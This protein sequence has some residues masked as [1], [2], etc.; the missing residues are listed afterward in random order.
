L[1]N[2]KSAEKRARVSERRRLINSKTLS[3]VRSAEKKVR[4]AIGAK[5]KDE[6]A[7][8][9]VVFKS[10]ITRAAQKGRMPVRTASRKISRISRAI[11]SL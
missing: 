3:A 8:A 9:L 2:H 1:A 6:S 11:S 5:N 10:A 7:K 4:T